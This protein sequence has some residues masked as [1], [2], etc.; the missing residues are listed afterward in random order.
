LIALLVFFVTYFIFE[1]PSNV[2]LRRVGAVN[3]LGSFCLLWGLVGFRA[4]PAKK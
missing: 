3:W 1:M 4:E 2:V